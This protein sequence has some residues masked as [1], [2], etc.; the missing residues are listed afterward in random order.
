MNFQTKTVRGTLL[1][2]TTIS[3]YS[4][5]LLSSSKVSH[6]YFLQNTFKNWFIAMARKY[7]PTSLLFLWLDWMYEDSVARTLW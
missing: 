4:T 6:P 1:A 3:L 7:P 2:F 5:H